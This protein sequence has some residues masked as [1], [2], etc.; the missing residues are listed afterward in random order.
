MPTWTRGVGNATTARHSL[1]CDEGQGAGLASASTGPLPT[2][3]DSTCLLPTGPRGPPTAW[4]AHRDGEGGGRAE[5]GPPCHVPRGLPSQGRAGGWGRPVTTSQG[6]AL[7]ATLW[8]A[9]LSSAQA[10]QASPGPWQ[11]EEPPLPAA[12]RSAEDT[13]RT[14]GGQTQSVRSEAR[15]IQHSRTGAN[16]TERVRSKT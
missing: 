10:P 12:S 3:L 11:S 9:G 15:F 2:G 13:R 5:G 6:H 7:G 1:R 14:E 8:G 16:G 4:F